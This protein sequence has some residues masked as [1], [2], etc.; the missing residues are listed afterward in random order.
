MGFRMGRLRHK[1]TFQRQA[2]TQD[3]WGEEDRTWSNLVTKGDGSVRCS[4]EPLIGRELD[5]ARGRDD[6]TT[7][8]IRVRWRKAIQD[9][10]ASDRAVGADGQVYDI[11]E[12]INVR[13][14][15]RELVIRCVSA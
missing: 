11:K 8:K 10:R 2:D 7:H 5:T 14:L 13:K 15:N 1:V 6:E 9:L 4:I 3:D 12:I